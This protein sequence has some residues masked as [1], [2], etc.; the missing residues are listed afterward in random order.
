MN[1]IDKEVYKMVFFYFYFF[2]ILPIC[3]DFQISSSPHKLIKLYDWKS[4]LLT[5]VYFYQ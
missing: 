1:I 4:P 3:G 5:I 2:I